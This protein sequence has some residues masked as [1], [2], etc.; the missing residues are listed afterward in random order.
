MKSCALYQIGKTMAHEHLHYLGKANRIYRMLPYFCIRH[1]FVVSL[2]IYYLLIKAS[3]NAPPE[4]GSGRE[5]HCPFTSA[6]A[7]EEFIFADSSVIEAG[8]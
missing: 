5:T 4:A 8:I 1:D 2:A 3:S 7:F 6:L